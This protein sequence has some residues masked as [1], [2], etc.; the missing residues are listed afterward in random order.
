MKSILDLNPLECSH[1]PFRRVFA[2]FHRAGETG[3][4]PIFEPFRQAISLLECSHWPFRRVLLFCFGRP[5][6][7]VLST[8]SKGGERRGR[9]WRLGKGSA[10]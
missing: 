5:Q 2:Y 6:Y 8:P 10:K 1:W 7:A 4:T 3:E 9:V